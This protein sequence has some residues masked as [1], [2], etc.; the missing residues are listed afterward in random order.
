MKLDT[1][2]EVNVASNKGQSFNM[3]TTSVQNIQDLSQNLKTVY[4]H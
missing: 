4:I 2:T 1:S 3:Q